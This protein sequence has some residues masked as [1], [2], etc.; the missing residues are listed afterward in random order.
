MEGLAE[1]DQRILHWL[2]VGDWKSG[3]PEKANN[4][5]RPDT[6]EGEVFVASW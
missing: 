4:Y 1:K 6:K 2:M 5:Y 3:L